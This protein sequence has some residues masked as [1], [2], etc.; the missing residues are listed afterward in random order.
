MEKA[1]VK[2][3][4]IPNPTSRW[5]LAAVATFHLSWNK[6]I[7]GQR[8]WNAATRG[9]EWGEGGLGGW[10]APGSISAGEASHPLKASRNPAGNRTAGSGAPGGGGHTGERSALALPPRGGHGS[11]CSAHLHLCHP[12]VVHLDGKVGIREFQQLAGG[13]TVNVFGLKSDAR[14]LL[15]L[16][17]PSVKNV[18][19]CLPS[20]RVLPG[21]AVSLNEKHVGI[22]LRTRAVRGPT[23][24]SCGC[25]E[26]QRSSCCFLC[27]RS[28][29]SD[30]RPRKVPSSD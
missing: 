23:E 7:K 5:A 15:R 12:Q 30:V 17:I 20:P 10:I 18:G 1:V 16:C 24:H 27:P 29:P 21:E 2:C 13:P 25:L 14:I 4:I 11:W 8:Q 22:A 26:L 28:W 6:S 19:C 3:G 9:K